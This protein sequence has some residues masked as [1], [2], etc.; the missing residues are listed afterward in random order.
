[1]GLWRSGRL[2]ARAGDASVFDTARR[3]GA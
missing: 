1:M 3:K 2:T